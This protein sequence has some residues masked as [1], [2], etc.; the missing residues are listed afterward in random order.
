MQGGPGHEGVGHVNVFAGSLVFRA[1]RPAWR[2][3]L[4]AGRDSLVGRFFLLVLRVIARV[5]SDSGTFG[6]RR[7]GSRVLGFTDHPLALLAISRPYL[8]LRR[9]IGAGPAGKAARSVRHQVARSALA[10]GSWVTVVGAGVC[11]LGWGRLVLLL[12][13]GITTVDNT[14]IP[15]ASPGLR[16]VTPI[17]LVVAGGLM[18]LSGPRLISAYSSGLVGRGVTFVTGSNPVVGFARPASESW[19]KYLIVTIA[20]LLAAVAGVAGGTTHGSGAVVLV[21]LVALVCAFVVVL[22]RPEAVLLAVA[23]F[24]WLDWV[25]RRVMGGAGPLWDEAL[26]VSSVLLLLWCVVMLRRWQLWT[27]PITLPLLLAFVVATGSVV[28]NVVPGDVGL[29]ALRVLFEPLLFYFLGFLFPKD[30]KWVRATIVLF[31]LTATTLALHGLYQYL[32]HAPMPASWVDVRETGIGTRAYS[33]IGNPNGLG[34]FLLMGTL[35]SMSLALSH[36]PR[37]TARLLWTLSCAIQV[38]AIAVTF[39]RGAWIGLAAGVITLV[40]MAHRRFLVPIATAAV[41]GWF[42]AP[43]AFVDRL[44]FAFS[45]AYI[46]KSSEAGRIYVWRMALE[47]AGSHPW[48]G[49]GLGTFGGTAA[50]TFGYGRL[51]VDN[52]YLQLAAEGGLVL[53]ALFLW[54][55]LRAL[56]GLVRGYGATTDRFLRPLAAGA[57]GAFVAVA[58]ANATASVWETLTV[59]V[60]FWFLTGLVTSA[61]LHERAVP[62]EEA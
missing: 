37:R 12:T 47:Y 32:T 38:A 43:R 33:I 21:L 30:K 27:V 44:T 8:W 46:T 24:P 53:V 34:A 52:F 16:L 15:L 45:S 39:S 51:W 5:A 48:F 14:G 17:L 23:A 19:P 25:A 36:Q 54:I 4:C 57:V 61:C 60:G 40:I 62:G 7:V 20:A 42:V 29:Y 13:Q 55:L 41:A 56:K 59:G 3:L 1:A 18:L 31:V 6:T 26:L 22:I 11:A 28:V 9:R 58:V 49:L 10:G 2:W 50:V 35:V